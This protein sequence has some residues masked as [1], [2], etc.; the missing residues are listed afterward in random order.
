FSRD[1][2]SDVCSSDLADWK[3][4]NGIEPRRDHWVILRRPDS[5]S[6]CIAFRL[7]STC[8]ISCIT[9]DAEMYGMTFSANRLK[10]DRAPPENMLRSEGRRV[11]NEGGAG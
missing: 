11:G 5:P 6:F 2:S 4:A 1:W 7:G 3:I 9:M 10:R 8:T